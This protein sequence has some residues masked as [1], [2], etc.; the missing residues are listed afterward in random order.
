[1]VAT[2]LRRQVQRKYLDPTHIVQWRSASAMWRQR[3]IEQADL[4]EPVILRFASDRFMEEFLSVA[5]QVPQRLGEWQAQPETWRELATTPSLQQPPLTP[6]APEGKIL[7]LYQP[8]HQR[9]YLVTA[10]LVC[11]QPGLPDKTLNLGNQEKVSF[12]VR[13]LLRPEEGDLTVEHAWV[14]GSWQTVE[15]PIQ[16][17]A[18]EETLP[19]FPTTY[20]ADG[21]QRRL[22]AGLVPVTERERYLIAPR[23]SQSV[24]SVAPPDIDD[25]I[26]RL[27]TLFN[28][29]VLAPWRA[30]LRQV[31]TP[32]TS[33]PEDLTTLDVDE[34][35]AATE[36]IRE[37]LDND[38]VSR[39]SILQTTRLQRDQLQ[40]PS[41]YGLL[42]FAN[43]LEKHLNRVWQ[44]ITAAE[45]ANN[46]PTN[47]RAL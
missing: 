36:A 40:M 35:G 14:G 27:V 30:L 43:F 8:A 6:P 13:R 23:R 15:D 4:R 16:L 2:P 12:V 3:L 21:G 31:V 32:E 20:K 34:L 11:R 24:D 17:V 33:L 37:G 9:Y 44:V 28:I 26:D 1:M 39:A 29:D 5:Q 38:D 18:G 46:L 22:F 47:Q 41:W 42:D 19:M 45:T 25:K 7:K 10:S